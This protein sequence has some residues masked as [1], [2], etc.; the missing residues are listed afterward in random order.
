MKGIE[1]N[2][3]ACTNVHYFCYPLEH[4][5]KKQREAGYES[6]ELYGGTP[7]FWLDSYAEADCWEVKALAER[8]GLRIVAFTPEFASFRHSLCIRD[9]AWREKSLRYY[10]NAVKAAAAM[11]TDIVVLN[12]VGAFRDVDWKETYRSV[13]EN[14]SRLCHTAEQYGVRLAMETVPYGEHGFVCTLEQL[15]RLME[16]VASPY[17]KATLDLC[18]AAAAGEEPARWFRE[19]GEEIVHVHFNDGRPSGHTVWGEGILPMRRYAEQISD[20]G[21]SGYFVQELANYDYYDEPE[22]ADRRNMERLLPLVR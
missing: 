4:A 6:M 2:R 13:C 15:K 16:D 10:E 11:G 22:L 17:L 5:V 18:S 3:L 14:L 12:A 20:A 7:H 21:Y 19:L 9:E 8:F 1:R